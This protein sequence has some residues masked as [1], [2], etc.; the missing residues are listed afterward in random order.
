MPVLSNG[1]SAV[2][3]TAPLWHPGSIPGAGVENLYEG[4]FFKMNLKN[5]KLRSRVIISLYVIFMI[6]LALI[7][8]IYVDKENLQKLVQNTGV[9]GIILYFLIGVIYV[10]F[11]PL[12]NTFLLVFSGYLFGGNLGFIV[13]FL[14]TTVG[15]FLIIFLVKLYGRPLLKKMISKKFYN[16]FDKITQ[17]IGPIM[18]LIVYVLPFTP[19]D[20]LTYIVAAG[21]IPIKRFVLPIL[22]GTIAKAAYSYI[23]DSGF[24]G[25]LVATYFRII[26]LVVGVIV[27]GIQ[28]YFVKRRARRFLTE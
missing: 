18:L 16:R 6:I 25:V 8:T 5:E 24:D 13:N 14:S 27:V 17:K 22:F 26:L 2:S 4:R 28:E 15:L 20:E 12:F 11:T 7:F 3:N 9:W 10:S 19:D 21:P 23:G 1:R